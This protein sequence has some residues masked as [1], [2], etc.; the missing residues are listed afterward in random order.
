MLDPQEIIFGERNPGFLW[1]LADTEHQEALMTMHDQFQPFRDIVSLVCGQEWSK[2]VMEDQKFD[3]TIFRFPL[4]NEISEISDNLYDADKV[5]D[6]FDSFITDAEL[7]LLFLKNVTSVSL[8]HIDIDG[9]VNS[10]LQV[11]SSVSTDIILRSEDKTTTGSTKFKVISLNPNTQ[12]E[13]KWLVTTCTMKAGN[14]ENLDRLAEKLSFFPR[15]DL[16]FPC[17]ERRDCSES[18]LSCFL[19]LPNNESN[20]TGLPVYVNACFGLTDNRREIKWQEEDQKHD[21]HAMW[22]E[23]LMKEVLP[24]A[25]L[26][27]IQDAI[28]LAQQ[29]MLPVASVYNLWPD[30][31][32][33]QHR[34]KWHAVALDVLS[35]LFRQN[36]AVLSLAKDERKFI[37]PSEA[38][39]PCNG[40]TSH[41]IL[42][43]IK[44]TLVSFG[45]NL[46]TL[47]GSVARTINEAYPH[48]S[49][50]KHVTP[51]FLRDTLRRVGVHNI[52]KLDRL[53]LLEYIL[54]DGKY[55]E[56]KG[57]QLLPISDRS[58]RS[59]TDREEDIALI[60]SNEFPR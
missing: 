27:I 40:P 16:A 5:V 1:S 26:K 15:V 43:A 45:E 44:R 59:F 25:Y 39:F 8:I 36:V 35:H 4:R 58:F 57:L 10:R 23:L 51:T 60:D 48:S 2:V 22:N 19:P 42:A 28:K 34:D 41:E 38:V 7:S 20:K 32:Q 52:S 31:A 14:I 47:P 21:E 56:L 6:L 49:T 12:K 11:K 29:S 33:L 50:L 53:C 30:L 37:T 17:G 54:S 3:G 18:R 55:R 46:V 24:Q 9:T 13:K